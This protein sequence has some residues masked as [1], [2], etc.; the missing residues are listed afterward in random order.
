MK[1]HKILLLFFIFIF[2]KVED[3]KKTKEELIPLF[4]LKKKNIEVCTAFIVFMV[5]LVNLEINYQR[6]S[7]SLSLSWTCHRDR[8]SLL[9]KF[10]PKKKK[11]KF[12]RMIM[13]P[14]K[15]LNY[16]IVV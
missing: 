14:T 6:L 16:Y 4:D 10:G 3:K 15:H 11:K 8:V 12:K 9:I 1:N 2:Y 7:L 13:M 5:N